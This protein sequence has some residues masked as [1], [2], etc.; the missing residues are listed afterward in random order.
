MLPTVDTTSSINC[1]M[2]DGVR[3]AKRGQYS[4]R[5]QQCCIVLGGARLILRATI[6]LGDPMTEDCAHSCSF[7]ARDE[8]VWRAS[9]LT[10]YD[11]ST[12][13][14]KQTKHCFCPSV[15]RRWLFRAWMDD[16]K[17]AARKYRQFLHEENQVR[18]G[19]CQSGEVF[20]LRFSFFRLA[21]WIETDNVFS[22]IFKLLFRCC[23]DREIQ[24]RTSYNA[25][26]LT[27]ESKINLQITVGNVRIK[28]EPFFSWHYHRR[29]LKVKETTLFSDESI[30]SSLCERERWQD[31]TVQLGHLLDLSTY[32]IN[33]NKKLLFHWIPK[34]SQVP[35]FSYF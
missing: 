28:R 5:V 17:W 29:S 34:L 11:L 8:L 3:V 14:N 24:K 1:K 20:C 9:S 6:W 30:L 13:R 32:K 25:D 15:R 4:L 33:M 16:K 21:V 12:Y 7:S 26:I 2:L 18:I 23:F 22:C 31:S 19:F 35:T 10:D 27:V